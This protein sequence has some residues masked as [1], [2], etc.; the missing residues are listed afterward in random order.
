MCVCW[1]GEKGGKEQEKKGEMTE[2]EKENELDELKEHT[3]LEDIVME[4]IQ[5]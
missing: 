3:E 2:R 5:N 4:S 1:K